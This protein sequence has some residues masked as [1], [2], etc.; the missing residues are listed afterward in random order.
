MYK[1][2]RQAIMEI[3]QLLTDLDWKPLLFCNRAFS[4]G[5]A[6][7]QRKS[8]KWFLLS[9][10]ESVTC[11]CAYKLYSR[12]MRH[13]SRGRIESL[14]QILRGTTPSTR[15]PQP[16]GDGWISWNLSIRRPKIMHNITVHENIFHSI[17]PH[18]QHFQRI[19]S[20]SPETQFLGGTVD[21]SFAS[22]LLFI[23]RARIPKSTR[24]S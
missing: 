1:I 19:A 5:A 14:S 6:N 7:N 13:R 3:R 20:I 21:V 16:S 17:L 15:A 24:I 18:C 4:K 10:I 9:N 12:C 23:A 11:A 8:D 2:K 22:P